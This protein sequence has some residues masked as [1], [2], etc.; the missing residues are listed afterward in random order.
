[1]Y[2]SIYSMYLRARAVPIFVNIFIKIKNFIQKAPI[3]SGFAK[4]SFLW[5]IPFFL[6][7]L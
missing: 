2:V 4:P 5:E 3:E 6:L 1:M 7:L